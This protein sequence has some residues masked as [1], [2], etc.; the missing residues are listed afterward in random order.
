LV[1]EDDIQETP[2]QRK[3]QP[4]L[5]RSGTILGSCPHLVQL[6]GGIVPYNLLQYTPVCPRGVL[7]D[8]SAALQVELV[9]FLAYVIPQNHSFP[10]DAPLEG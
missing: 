5:E 10:P 6:S 9:H 8:A 4:N 3:H 2:N 7:R 1:E